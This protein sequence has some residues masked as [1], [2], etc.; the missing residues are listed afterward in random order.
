MCTMKRYPQHF[1]RCTLLK[2]T[3]HVQNIMFDWFVDWLVDWLVDSLIDWLVDWL[4][5][6]LVDWWMDARTDGWIT[7]F[8]K[9]PHLPKPKWQDWKTTFFL[10]WQDFRFFVSVKWFGL[11]SSYESHLFPG[12]TAKKF[13]TR[14]LNHTALVEV[15]NENDT[16]ISHLCWT[17]RRQHRFWGSW[18]CCQQKHTSHYTEDICSHKHTYIYIYMHILRI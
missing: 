4:L 2:Q 5:D 16:M 3:K 13:T 10:G 14:F 9:M 17:S 6:W 18:G 11:A 7:H 1:L 12:E 15:A 8:K